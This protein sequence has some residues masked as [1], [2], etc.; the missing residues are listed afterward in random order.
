LLYPELAP[1]LKSFIPTYFSGASIPFSIHIT[2][3]IT[4]NASG[5][6]V[7]WY[8]PYTL[9]DNTYSGSFSSFFLNNASTYTGADPGAFTNFISTSI[10][11]Y[12]TTVLSASQYRLVSSCIY[13]VLESSVLNKQGKFGGAVAVL[14]QQ[15][16]DSIG[17]A[18]T[19]LGSL[20]T[21]VQSSTVIAGLPYYTEVQV[22][23]TESVMRLV[24]YPANLHDYDYYPI[25][26]NAG[27]NYGSLGEM[28]TVFL[29]YGL[30]LGNAVTVNIELYLNFEIIPQIG[31]ST[32]RFVDNYM[33]FEDPLKIK[34]NFLSVPTNVARPVISQYVG[35]SLM[36]R[37][38]V[39]QAPQSNEISLSKNKN[40][41][42]MRN[43]NN[44]DMRDYNLR[45]QEPEGTIGLYDY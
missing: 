2:K 8:D 4:T 37:M 20:P 7:A 30:G 41:N 39:Y 28:S 27:E 44:V 9:L 33:S 14:P 31:S 42:F 24:W 16:P 32:W 12:Q 17:S 3:Q 1:S 13:T 38:P 36:G 40:P 18:L 10:G 43:Y 26:D 11:S 45:F 6:F 23:T 25:N 29:F 35:D 21:S 19:P 15:G 22:N 5:N 34:G